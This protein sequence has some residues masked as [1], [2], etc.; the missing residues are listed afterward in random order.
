MRTVADL[1]TASEADKAVPAWPFSDDNFFTTV[2]NCMD[3]TDRRCK[4]NDVRRLVELRDKL[5]P[6]GSRKDPA[7]PKWSPEFVTNEFIPFV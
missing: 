6:V 1:F 7:A 2:D 4:G 5:V 3:G